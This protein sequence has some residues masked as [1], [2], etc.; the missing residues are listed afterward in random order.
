MKFGNS[1]ELIDSSR[2][3][4]SGDVLARTTANM[5]SRIEMAK[6]VGACNYEAGTCWGQ[7][8]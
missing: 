4:I 7:E 1:K 6:Q 2:S 5:S 8:V 3:I